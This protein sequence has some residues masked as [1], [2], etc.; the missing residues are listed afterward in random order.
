MEPLNCTLQAEVSGKAVQSVKVWV[1]SQF[2][3]VDQAAIGRVPS[4]RR[5]RSRSTP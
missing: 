2:Q 1:G 4:C 5:P 3:T